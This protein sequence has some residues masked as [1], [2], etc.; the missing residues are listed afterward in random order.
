MCVWI[1]QGK[2]LMTHPT[3]AIYGTLLKDFA[4]LSMARAVEDQLFNDN[5]LKDSL[6]K[7][8]VVDF[9]QTVEIKGIKV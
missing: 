1:L 4:K 8:D 3:K 5:D 6:S 2:I 7:I 9:H